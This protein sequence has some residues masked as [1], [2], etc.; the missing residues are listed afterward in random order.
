MKAVLEHKGTTMAVASTRPSGAQS[1]PTST[2]RLAAFT[3]LYVATVLACRTPSYEHAYASST[4]A[5]VSQLH[6]RVEDEDATR[7]SDDA[8]PGEAEVVEVPDN[9]K[10]F[11]NGVVW[12]DVPTSGLPPPEGPTNLRPFGRFPELA[13]VLMSH[14]GDVGMPVPGLYAFDADRQRWRTLN[15]FGDPRIGISAHPAGEERWIVI[16]RGYG[17][18][19]YAAVEAALLTADLD[20]LVVVT[21]PCT[22]F[23]S[24][25]VQ[26]TSEGGWSFRCARNDGS[27]VFSLNLIPGVLTGDT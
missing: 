2:M 24:G 22:S 17:A 25:T 16:R 20:R 13:F 12:K 9:M 23:R 15:F 7:P 18:A 21:L 5:A 6:R 10:V 26:S 27:G 19:G 11:D 1:R 3:L 4:P 8:P 14:I